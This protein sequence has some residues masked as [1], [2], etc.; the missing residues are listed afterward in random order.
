[1]I[2]SPLISTRPAAN[3]PVF[4][5]TYRLDA[6]V[7][8]WTPYP[9]SASATSAPTGTDRTS[10]ACA[11]TRVTSTGAPS[12]LPSFDWSDMVIVTGTVAAPPLA[13]AV[14]TVP[15]EAT[16]PVTVVPEGSV[17]V[18]EMPALTR[19]CLDTSRSTLTVRVVP[20]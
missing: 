20:V 14:A 13:P 2:P 15:T 4:T 5:A 19:P 6:P 12:R 8:T 3:M 7:T 10:L 18:A 1:V 9:P 11:E 17:T 16:V